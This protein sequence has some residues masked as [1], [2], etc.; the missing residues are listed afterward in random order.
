MPEGWGLPDKPQTPVAA[1]VTGETHR[2]DVGEVNGR[3]FLHKV[4]VGVIPGVAAGREH[5]RGR[6]DTSAKI[7]FLRYFFRRLARA[8]RAEPGCCAVTVERFMVEKEAG[9]G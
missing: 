6:H 3:I 2:I 1:L 9:R 7:G 8:R 4:V 5:I